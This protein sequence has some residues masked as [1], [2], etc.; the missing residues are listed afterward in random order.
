[1]AV[2]V[3]FDEQGDVKF[4]A[5]NS[6]YFGLAAVSTHD[7][8]ALTAALDGLRHSLWS[9]EHVRRGYFHAQQ[10][11]N[12]VR[13]AVFGT[14]SDLPLVSCNVAM[15]RKDGVYPSLRD[16]ASLYRLAARF[17]LSRAL[18]SIPVDEEVTLVAAD[19]PACPDL[20]PVL[21]EAALSTGK[22]PP[23]LRA[24][25]APS[26]AHAGLQYAD[27]LAWA[28]LRWRTRGETWLGS[29]RAPGRSWSDFVAFEA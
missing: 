22:A 17:A 21:A 13:T 28:S 3:F 25:Q 20:R 23:S 1:V 11:C 2:W 15:L 6:L 8:R 12:V 24:L 14:F 26:A 9:E 27:Y 7:P 10:D 16:P 5:H 18:D 29:T 4:G 19:W